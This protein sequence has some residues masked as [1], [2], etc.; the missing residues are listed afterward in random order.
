M[1]MLLVIYYD[2][3]DD[4]DDDDNV[5]AVIVAAI[6]AVGWIEFK[7]VCASSCYWT[8]SFCQLCAACKSCAYSVSLTE[9]P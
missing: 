8:V 2:V 9:S 6:V 3:S 5:L 1:L 7:K 4:N